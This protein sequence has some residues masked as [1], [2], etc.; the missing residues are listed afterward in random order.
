MMAGFASNDGAREELPVFVVGIIIR[1]W[2]NLKEAIADLE[3]LCRP[4]RFGAFVK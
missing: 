3:S 1:G 2:K 4:G